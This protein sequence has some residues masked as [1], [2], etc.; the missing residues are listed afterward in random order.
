M[1]HYLRNMSNLTPTPI[2]DKN[3][4]L[5]TVHKKTQVPTSS[6]A[7][8]SVA[9]PKPDNIVNT[10]S[11]RLAQEWADS[12][13]NNGLDHERA[14]NF[15]L[16][17]S[18]EAFGK[19]SPETIQRVY[20]P[21]MTPGL[22]LSLINGLSDQWSEGNINDYMSIAQAADELEMYYKEVKLFLAAFEY[23]KEIDPYEG[24]PYPEKRAKQVDALTRVLWH[25]YRNPHNLPDID[26]WEEFKDKHDEW[27]EVPYIKD[28]KLRA[29]ILTSG[30]DRDA[31]VEI[32]TERSVFDADQIMEMLS[33]NDASALRAGNL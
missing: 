30:H 1:S 18:R 17:D 29:L 2:V 20:G 31:I 13:S 22:R 12:Q 10:V 21:E 24:G 14:Y 26:I 32:I 4:K 8:P 33:A 25:M 16:Q 28:E 5:T 3:G 15:A 6:K 11:H 7:L 9:L 19:C 27:E 23:F